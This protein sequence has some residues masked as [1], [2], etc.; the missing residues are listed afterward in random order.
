MS[1]H[2]HFYEIEAG[3]DNG[4]AMESETI[5][6]NGA[7][8]KS[9]MSRGNFLNSHKMKKIILMLVVSLLF[10]LNIYGQ[11]GNYFELMG[12]LSHNGYS[13]STDRYADLKQ[14]QTTSYTRTFYEGTEYLIFG[15]S[16]DNDVLDVD[17]YLYRMDGTEYDKDTDSESV[18]VVEFYPSFTREMKVTVKNYSSLTPNYASRC[19][20]IIAYK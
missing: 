10:S 1:K 7:S 8:P 20:I 4:R 5:Q 18:A 2:L 15:L 3:A 16:D 6:K 17:I 12:R 13:I 19:R 11:S 9:L 14:G